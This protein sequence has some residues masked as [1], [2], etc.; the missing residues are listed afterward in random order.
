MWKKIVISAISIFS[1]PA[2][3]EVFPFLSLN[4]QHEIEEKSEM[5]QAKLLSFLIAAL[6]LSLNNEKL[7]VCEQRSGIHVR[8]QL[9]ADQYEHMSLLII[10]AQYK[11][12]LHLPPRA[13]Q[14]TEPGHYAYTIFNSINTYTHDYIPATAR[15]CSRVII[16]NAL[17]TY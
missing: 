17:L 11:W 1:F 13:R 3:P 8:L 6:H 2:K 15:L 5:K 10:S 4:S 16:G 12:A 14:S 9:T 7:R